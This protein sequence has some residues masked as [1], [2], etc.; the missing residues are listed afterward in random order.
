M[1]NPLE[2]EELN[3]ATIVSEYGDEDSARALL[4]SLRW[5]SGAV[6]PHCNTDKPYSLTAKAGSRV[7]CRAGLYKCRS[8][9]K[10]F[11]FK[12]GTIFEDSK[13][14][15]SKWCMAI[16]LICSSKKAI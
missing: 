15:C 13:I 7:K 5:P 14:K 10:Q 16:A 12:V 1:K 8:C 6:C 11:T 2:K 4:E 3:L 9:R